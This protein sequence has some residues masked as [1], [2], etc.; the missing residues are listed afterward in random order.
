MLG[1][2]LCAAS[3]LLVLPAIASAQTTYTWSGA[4][5]G[6]PPEWSNSGNWSGG[7]APT[8]STDSTL[9]FPA[10]SC[11][12]TSGCPSD[13]NI[14]GLTAGTLSIVT[15]TASGNTQPPGPW[16]FTDHD[17]ANNDPLTLDSG[18]SESL[19]SQGDVSSTAAT[20]SI[21]IALGGP[22]TWTIDGGG[23]VFA[24]DV[25][26]AGATL[27]INFDAT[28]GGQLQ[29]AGS[30]NEVGAVTAN[31]AGNIV[32][33][34][35]PDSTGDLNGTNGNAVT[36]GGY[37]NGTGTVG[38]LTMNGG[39]VEPG[40]GGGNTPTG[41]LV[42]DGTTL[43]SDSS[44]TFNLGDTTGTTAGT[45]YPQLTAPG[46]TVDLA[47]AVLHVS[48]FTSGPNCLSPAPALGNTYTL[49]SAATVTGTFTNAPASGDTITDECNSNVTYQIE[50]NTSSSPET[51]TAKVVSSG[52]TATG[53]TTSLSANPPSSVTNET[54]TLTASVSPQ[55]GTTT[56]TGTVNFQDNGNDISGCSSQPLGS[57]GTATCQTSFTEG[58]QNL[59]AIYSPSGSSFSGSSGSDQMTVGRDSTTT[60]LSASNSSPSEGQSVTYTATV[61]PGNSGPTEPSGSVTFNDGG[62]PISGCTAQSLTAGSSSSTATCTTSYSSAGSH[63]ITASYDG[64][65]NFNSSPPSSP[66]T[67][68][69]EPSPAPA[70]SA[71]TE[72]A[73]SVGTTVATL[74]GVV[75]TKGAA[76]TWQFQYGEST[77][78][79]KATPVQTSA[80]GQSQPAAVS[81][82]LTNLNPLT[83]YH[84]RLVAITQ[85]SSGQTP[86]TSDGQDLTFTT[87]A[88]GSLGAKFSKL[89]LSGVFVSVPL[90][91]SSKLKC[92]GR[93]LITTRA[94]VGK[95]EKLGTVICDRTS[96]TIKANKKKTVRAKIYRACMSLVRHARG[97]HIKVQFA[98]LTRTGQFG[99]VKNIILSL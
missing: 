64:D 82:T 25:T 18:F 62:S 12:S 10:S 97:H 13:D 71:T 81:W 67:V 15:P 57:S 14:S 32:L 51:V 48:T 77:A 39:G 38:A 61:T 50:Y 88:T 92:S 42:T 74:Q 83:V 19:E 87:H 24:Q 80:A 29:L 99:I 36:I 94:R 90:K 68:T 11:T 27:A 30:S 31:D 72:A 86:V 69:V 3:C 33:G 26:G 73:G 55:S 41:S 16:S 35:G 20:I 84:F 44:A 2:L 17:G 4:A 98:P 28:N 76:V 85:S 47:N 23:P 45:D 22:N 79:N 96:F 46:K 63:S 7:T 43:T 49:I 40:W 56:P 9:S 34:A 21:P 52:A 5:G 93:F 75:D 95:H 78:Y 54:V 59:T 6:T 89:K 1:G 66:Q 58:T 70:I 60:S 37:L 53:T 91:C 8:S 65:S